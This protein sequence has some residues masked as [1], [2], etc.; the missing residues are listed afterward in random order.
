MLHAMCVY[1]LLWR[2]AHAPQPPS[3]AL[4]TQVGRHPQLA[5]PYK[6]SAADEETVRPCGKLLQ[7]L[8]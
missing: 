1:P 7:Q 8:G 2:C 5:Y 3:S 4:P 6:L